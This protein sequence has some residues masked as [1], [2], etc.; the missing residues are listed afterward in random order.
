MTKYAIAPEGC[1]SYLTAGKRYEVR[2]EYP[3]WCD[4]VDDEGDFINC[5]KVGCSFLDG[6]DWDFEEIEHGDDFS[7]CWL[8]DAAGL[9]LLRA[10]W[11]ICGCIAGALGVLVWGV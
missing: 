6:Q 2:Y 4:I 3:T 5:N 9:I 11:F 10:A 1:A 7:P 8:D